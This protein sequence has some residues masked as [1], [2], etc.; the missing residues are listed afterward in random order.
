MK[1]KIK[2]R[3]EYF[4]VNEKWKKIYNKIKYLKN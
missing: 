2:K 4:K 3:N 1:N